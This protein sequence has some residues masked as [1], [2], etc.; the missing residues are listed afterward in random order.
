MSPAWPWTAAASR[1]WPACWRSARARRACCGPPA[2]WASRRQA[3]AQPPQSSCALH[4]PI[5]PSKTTLA[6]HTAAPQLTAHCWRLSAGGCQA[7]SVAEVLTA[8]RD[9][10]HDPAF[11]DVQVRKDL[12]GVQRFVTAHRRYFC[13]RY[14]RAL[15]LIQNSD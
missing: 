1:A 15:L 10:N 11:R 3:R 4:I 5:I 14:S 2:S 9:D 12:F 6:W 7:D 8:L 13:A